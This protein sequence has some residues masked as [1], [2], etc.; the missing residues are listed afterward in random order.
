MTQSKCASE[1]KVPQREQGRPD[2]S[3]VAGVEPEWGPGKASSYI[4]LE[5]SDS[6]CS[7]IQIWSCG[8]SVLQIGS[9]DG[10]R[11]PVRASLALL[12]VGELVRCGWTPPWQWRE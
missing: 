4:K 9:G 1:K 7:G 2:N 6:C 10:M 8:Q 5:K 3:G 11:F 12:R